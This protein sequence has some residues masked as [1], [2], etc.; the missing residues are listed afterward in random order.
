MLM[1]RLTAASSTRQ[2]YTKKKLA[3]PSTL[4]T[5]SRLRKTAAATKNISIVELIN[6]T[7]IQS[8]F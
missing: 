6:S 4:G 3:I 8:Q 1:R 5:R 7:S 2:L